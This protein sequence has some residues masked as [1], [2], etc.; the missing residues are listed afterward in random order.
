MVVGH[1]PLLVHDVTT[2]PQPS[3]KASPTTNTPYSI[4]TTRPLP[5]TTQHPLFPLRLTFSPPVP[6]PPTFQKSPSNKTLKVIHAVKTTKMAPKECSLCH[7]PR[8]ILVRCQTDATGAWH[9]VCPGKC[10]HSVSGGVEDARGLEGEFPYYRYGGMVSADL[11]LTM[12]ASGGGWFARWVAGIY[13]YIYGFSGCGG[14]LG[15]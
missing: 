11:L 15:E 2:P 7:A 8:Q 9:F 13:I 6:Q 1:I 3:T 14:W 4:R 5:L 12:R 10:W